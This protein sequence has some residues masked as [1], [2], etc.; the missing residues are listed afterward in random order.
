M[1]FSPVERCGGVRLLTLIAT[2]GERGGSVIW[3]FNACLHCS[4]GAEAIVR[5]VIDQPMGRPAVRTYG[6]EKYHTLETFCF[7][8]KGGERLLTCWSHVAKKGGRGVYFHHSRCFAHALYLVALSVS[9]IEHCCLIVLPGLYAPV[10]SFVISLAAPLRP[11]AALLI[12]KSLLNRVFSPLD[13]R[14]CGN[15]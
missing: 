12:N 2:R 7:S 11:M 1:C 9:F 8:E 6:V 13:V 4:L 5:V 3:S 14:E 15:H 10:C